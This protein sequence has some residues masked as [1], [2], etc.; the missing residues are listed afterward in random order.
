MF[1]SYSYILSFRIDLITWLLFYFCRKSIL[2]LNV[3]YFGTRWFF[4][5]SCCQSWTKLCRG[6]LIPHSSKGLDNL[7]RC[8]CR[9]AG[10]VLCASE[11]VQWAEW[12]CIAAPTLMHEAYLLL[13]HIN[14]QHMYA[15]GRTSV[16]VLVIIHSL[17]NVKQ[18]STATVCAVYLTCFKCL[19]TVVNM[20]VG[21]V[22]LESVCSCMYVC[23]CVCV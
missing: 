11:R 8:A 12:I 7:L 21:D 6:D 3:R 10:Q 18:R 19:Q 16:L 17:F 2:L 1:S 20:P 4:K 22:V 15:P 23:V 13:I 14:L 9:V 5:Q